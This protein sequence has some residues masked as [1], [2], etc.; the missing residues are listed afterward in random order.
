M[1]HRDALRLLAALSVIAL[2]TRG[3][4]AG[5][6]LPV[7]DT[8]L[9]YSR[10]S[11]ATFEPRRV[12]ET[13]NAAEVPRALV[14]STPDDGT[15]RLYRED[16]D[17]FVPVLR[18]YRAGVTPGN[19][20]R[21]PGTASYVAERLG[22]GIYRGIGEIHLID[23]AAA[24]A[25]QVR[26]L[27]AMAVQRDIILHVHCGAGP[28]RALFAIEPRLR[29]LWAHAGFTTPPDEIGELL[30]RHPRLWAELSFRAHDI[31]PGG[32]LDPA[33]RDL[34]LRHP[35][36]F[37]IGTD[38]YVEPRWAIYGEL[39]D[40]H[41]QWLAQLPRAVAE[42]IAYGNAVRLFGAGTNPALQGK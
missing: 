33:W 5:D 11:W 1:T 18:P 27:A 14:S 16:A 22:R 38:T 23:D 15:M 29:I 41:R 35:D 24:G 42:A 12:I 40:Q 28:V 20:L 9:H 8:H 32:R 31:A 34:L 17:R 3:L 39:V 7:F 21:D 13:L 4:A 26:R 36:R 30:D 19:W 25:P 6:Q 10:E 2:G 37:M